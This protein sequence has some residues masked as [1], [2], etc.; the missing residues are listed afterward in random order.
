M[1]NLIILAYLVLAQVGIVS[2]LLV[3][4]IHATSQIL[5]ANFPLLQW[6]DVTLPLRRLSGPLLT[7][8][9]FVEP[10]NRSR[11]QTPRLLLN[12]T[13]SRSLA[14]LQI[15]LLKI[16]ELW[17]IFFVQHWHVSGSITG[18]ELGPH[19]FQFTFESEKDLQRILAKAPTTSNVG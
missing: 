18:R 8:I 4:K 16:L 3:P 9:R 13:S 12:R 5:L 6:L 14:E 1:V 10:L 19:L 17:L 7:R 15:R 2:F 11:R